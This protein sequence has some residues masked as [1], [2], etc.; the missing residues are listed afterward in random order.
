MTVSSHYDGSADSY[1]LQYQR[2]NLWTHEDYPANFFRL[3]LVIERLKALRAQS[4]FEFGVGD[5]TPLV[6]IA[7]EGIRV[8]GFDIAPKMVEVAQENLVA[9]SLDPALVCLAD[10][11][12]SKTLAPQL[13]RHGQ[14]DAVMALG[15]IPHVKDDQQFIEAMS[16]FLRPGG[17]I[18]LEFRNSLFSLFT[19][20]RYTKE[21][22]LDELLVGVDGHTRDIVAAELDQRLAVN[23]PP[24]RTRDDGT[25]G[26]DEILARFH[27]PFELSDLVRQLGFE[28]LQFHWYHYHPAPPMLENAVGREAFRR[29]AFALEHERT[30]RGM[31]L[32]S[33]GV[34]E[35]VKR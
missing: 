5:A 31:F 33:A 9:N 8:A 4:L 24:P 35:A 28:D 17:T 22:I 34:I 26:Y 1:G 23:V 20:N 3:E 14:F 16:S 6:S 11:Q 18:F 12:D 25:P 15:V 2:E 13:E 30:W 27:N 19:F 21:F 29:G 32:C 10:A 7:K